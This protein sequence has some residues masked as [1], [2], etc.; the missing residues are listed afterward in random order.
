MNAGAYI[1]GD[2]N[3]VFRTV[4]PTNSHSTRLS[5]EKGFLL[6]PTLG[7][8]LEQQQVGV[9]LLLLARLPSA[10][11]HVPVSLLK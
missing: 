4:S 10:C 3:P 2:T 7:N 11:T 8:F 9:L 6:P 5:L 1:L